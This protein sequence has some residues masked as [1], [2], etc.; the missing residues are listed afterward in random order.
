MPDYF[1]DTMALLS[2]WSTNP[3]AVLQFT[4]EQVVSAAGNG[5]L[6]DGSECSTEIRSYFS[7]VRSEKLGEY[8]DSCLTSSFG[9]SG[10]VLQ[11]IVNELGRR[12]DYN[13]TNGRYQGSQNAVGNDGLWESPE[14]HQILVEVKTTDAYSISLD[15]IAQYRNALVERNEINDESSM[16]LVVGR[17]DTGQLEA[18]VRGSRY[19]WDMRLVSIDS[20]LRL[21]NLKENTEEEIT[22]SKIRTLLV[23]MEYTRIDKLIDVMF[24]AAKDV[25]KV[26]EIEPISGE[27]HPEEQKKKSTW[28]FTDSTLLEKKRE[29]ILSAISRVND[30]KLVKKSRA[31]YWDSGRE[32]RVASTISKRYPS[33][34]HTYWYAYHSSWQDFLAKAKTGY[35]VLGCMDLEIAFAVPFLAIDSKL[36]EFNITARNDS[37]YWHIFIREKTPG[38][39]LLL[40]SKTGEHLDLAPYIIPIS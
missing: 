9:N 21:V 8:A 15:T 38:T 29:E 23:P 13:V 7:Q 31:M 22:G 20:L 37:K 1:L 6:L 16:L 2:I 36:D 3:E 40:G 19:A 11:D 33:S 14:G 24:T 12:L 28:D 32:F 27:D 17:Y 39:Y 26:I 30:T 34:S 35:L 18:Q 4:I 10:K 25:E 5:K